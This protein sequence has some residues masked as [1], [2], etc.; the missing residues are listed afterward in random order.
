[1]KPADQPSACEAAGRAC[2]E[3]GPRRRAIMLTAV[4]VL[5]DVS[6]F[7][8]RRRVFRRSRRLATGFPRYLDRCAVT[9]RTASYS[10]DFSDR[11]TLRVPAP[12]TAM[13]AITHELITAPAQGTIIAPVHTYTDGQ[14]T[15]ITSLREV[16]AALLDLWG[17]APL[18]NTARDS[19]RI[20]YR[21]P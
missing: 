18:A 12:P 15:Q 16:S 14:Q 17:K 1:V 5:C 13:P 10:S 6:S 7:K 21:A 9:A 2:R 3:A 4:A 19:V 8:L 11:F 20:L